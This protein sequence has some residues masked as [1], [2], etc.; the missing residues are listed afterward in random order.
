MMMGQKKMPIIPTTKLW[1]I[2]PLNGEHQ[3]DVAAYLPPEDGN[4]DDGSH[5]VLDD[6]TLGG[7]A[8]SQQCRMT[9][10]EE[11]KTDT[12]KDYLQGDTVSGM[13]RQHASAHDIH[14]EGIHGFDSNRTYGA[15]K[16]SETGFSTRTFANIMENVFDAPLDRPSA[17][18][19][20]NTSIAHWS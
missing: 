4:D 9:H 15:Q 20:V 11:Q 8:R 10:F 6:E 17:A 12:D 3:T 18:M 14:F 7:S 16:A 2:A 5:I 13:G 19:S 1:L